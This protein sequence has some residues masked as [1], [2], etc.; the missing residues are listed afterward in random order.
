MELPGGCAPPDEALPPTAQSFFMEL[1]GQL[2]GHSATAELWRGSCGRV[3]IMMAA[4]PRS[5]SVKRH[6]NFCWMQQALRYAPETLCLGLKRQV[7]YFVL[8]RVKYVCS[9]YV[10]GQGMHCTR[11]VAGPSVGPSETVNRYYPCRPQTGPPAMP[12]TISRARG[13]IIN[14]AG[15][16]T[17]PPVAAVGEFI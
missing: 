11:R 15:G 6:R 9:P 12:I 14:P 17:A 13:C 5:S 10:P 2:A 3:S 8:V 7:M 4:G 16:P 1:S